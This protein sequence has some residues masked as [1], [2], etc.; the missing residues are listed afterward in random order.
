VATNRQ[1]AAIR[2]MDL[3]QNCAGDTPAVETWWTSRTAIYSFLRTVVLKSS[4]QERGYEYWHT[5]PQ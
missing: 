4:T 3:P 1:M 2:F 5:V